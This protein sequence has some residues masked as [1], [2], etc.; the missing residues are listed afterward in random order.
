MLCFAIYCS[1]GGT[2]NAVIEMGWTKSIGKAEKLWR[3]GETAGLY[4]CRVV[5]LQDTPVI[6]W[7]N[8]ERVPSYLD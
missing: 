5:C 8:G 1:Y 6:V 4:E 3:E 2:H 7:R